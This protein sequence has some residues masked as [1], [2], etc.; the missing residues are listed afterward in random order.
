MDE[1]KEEGKKCNCERGRICPLNGEC[2]ESGLVYKAKVNVDGE[3]QKD[4]IGMTARTFKERL[5]EHMYSMRHRNSKGPTELAKF[6]WNLNDKNKKWTIGW[7]RIGYGKP[8]EPGD[9]FCMLCNREKTEIVLADRNR[10]INGMHIIEKC[11]HMRRKMLGGM[12]NEKN[13]NENDEMTLKERAR[14]VILSLTPLKEE[15]LIRECEVKL[16]PMRY[17]ESVA[18]LEIRRSSRTRKP[19]DRLD[20]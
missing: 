4:Y 14:K 16:N 20:L 17:Q 3:G 6:I 7:E 10:T 19:R 12:K 11:R 1:N 8:F 2:L 18:P 15:H 9:R 13:I 5:N